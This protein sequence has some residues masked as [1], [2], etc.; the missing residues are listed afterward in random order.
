MGRATLQELSAPMD[1]VA[2]QAPQMAE[3]AA[4][5]REVGLAAAFKERDAPFAAGTPLD[6]ASLPKKAG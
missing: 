1:A 5:A 4:R 2:N 6:F 3:F